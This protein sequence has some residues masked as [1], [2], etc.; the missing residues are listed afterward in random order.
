MKKKLIWNLALPLAVGGLASLVSGGMGD[1]K[2]MNQPPLSPPGWVF[3]VVWT[4][5]YLAMGY[6]AYRV[7]TSDAEPEAIR[8]AM[9]FYYIQLGLNFLWPVLFFGFNAYLLAFVELLAL[10]VAVCVTMLK[11]YR[12]DERAGDLFLP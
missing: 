11:F 7:Q 5:L 1:F 2:T 9:L 6:A 4:L 12:T 10:W 3:P 8:R